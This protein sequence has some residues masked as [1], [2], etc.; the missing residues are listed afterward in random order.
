M[1]MGEWE[2]CINGQR[3][4]SEYVVFIGFGGGTECGQ[5]EFETEG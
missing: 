4:R 5:P 2:E 1:A 3:T